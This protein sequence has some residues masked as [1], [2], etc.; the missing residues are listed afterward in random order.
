MAA[1]P[2]EEQA[3][4][5]QTPA[6]APEHARFVSEEHAPARFT[7]AEVRR[8][9]ALM[10]SSD[11]MEIS[12][13][14]EEAGMRLVLRREVEVVG[15]APAAA[16]ALAPATSPA[17]AAALASGVHEV[18]PPEPEKLYVTSPIVGTFHPALKPS[19]NPLVQV[20]DSVREGQVVGGIETLNVMN[21]VEAQVAGRLVKILVEPGDAVEYGQ[22]LF[23]LVAE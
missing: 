2:K 19:Q 7:I 4:R 20:G 11:L 5:Q 21:E 1:K 18:A 10:N 14:R 22:P 9:I 23:E 16:A 13:E 6:P 17:S 12:I 8:L 15:D 3:N